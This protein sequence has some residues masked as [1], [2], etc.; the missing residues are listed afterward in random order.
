MCIKFL[1]SHGISLSSE[2]SEFCVLCAY[3]KAHRK[4]FHSRAVRSTKPGEQIDADVFG[5]MEEDSV[6]TSRFMFVLEDDYTKFRRDLH[7][8]R[9]C[10]LMCVF[11]KLERK[12][13][14]VFE[15]RA[16]SIV[17]TNC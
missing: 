3:G 5:P 17:R 9:L 16:C 10:T 2:K 11:T 15:V 12:L 8:R 6:G 14:E 13:K 4:S 7:Y 1:K